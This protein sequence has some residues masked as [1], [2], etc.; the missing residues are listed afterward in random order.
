VA[1][2]TIV[3]DRVKGLETD[4]TDCRFAAPAFSTGVLLYEPGPIS[5]EEPLGWM[6]E[7]ACTVC[8]QKYFSYQV[9]FHER[10]REALIENGILPTAHKVGPN[11]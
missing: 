8:K 6:M 2:K 5:E 1:D 7:F 11:Y 10:I 3:S 4:H 9:E